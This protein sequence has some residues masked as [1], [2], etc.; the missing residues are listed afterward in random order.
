MII[1]HRNP[2]DYGY[3]SKKGFYV[4]NEIIN[5][6]VAMISLF[7]IILIELFTGKT[8]LNILSSLSL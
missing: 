7:L 6:R 2:Y 8:L 1:N 5:G 3:S 4:Q